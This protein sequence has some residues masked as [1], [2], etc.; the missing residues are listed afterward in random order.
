MQIIDEVIKEPVG[1]AHRNKEEIISITKKF[2]IAMLKIDTANEVIKN[3][4]VIDLSNATVKI[5]H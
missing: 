4:N 2:A 1:G 5:I 3:D